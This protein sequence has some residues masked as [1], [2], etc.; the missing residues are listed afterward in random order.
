[1]PGL[2]PEWPLPALVAG[3]DRRSNLPLVMDSLWALLLAAMAAAP[4]SAAAA[5]APVQPS[6]PRVLADDLVRLGHVEWRLRRA[7]ADQ[8]P[9]TAP[10]AGL[11]L[12]YLG[13]YDAAD[14][15]LV[16]RETGL[17][18]LPR[19]LSAEPGGP[20]AA[21][22]IA[23]GDEVLAIAGMQVQQ[24]V[25][26]SDDALLADA[27]QDRIAQ[28]PAGAALELTVLRGGEAIA[29]RLVPRPVCSARMALKTDTAVE[30]YSDGRNVAINWGL[31]RFL[32]NDDELAL[33]AGHEYGHVIGADGERA[34]LFGGRGREDEA[35]L[36]GA[37]L[38]GCAG[39]DV[40]RALGFWDRF[41]RRDA[42][43][44]LRGPGHRSASG[45]HARLTAA[46]PSLAC[47]V[48]N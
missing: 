22:G 41:A 39:F 29:V 18:D 4:A 1:M 28:T 21:A 43:G 24:L 14:R 48:R 2:P 47:P 27:I 11:V 38:A 20:A 32:A 25:M 23:A 15:A 8:C 31:M 19:V 37:R 7:A 44:W 40:A 6:W 10:A 45:R 35:D 16:H 42:L 12:D 26:G 33:V 34:G 3:P 17:G 46:L 13:A 30:A 5:P 9:R 36:A